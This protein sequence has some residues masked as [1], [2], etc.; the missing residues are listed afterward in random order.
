[1]G[2]TAS[3]RRQLI[4]LLCRVARADGQVVA[5]ERERLQAV[6]VR[7]GEHTVS[8]AE[9]DTWL[10]HGAPRV[11]GTLSPLARQAFMNEAMGV[12][13]ADRH[14][15]P[16]ELHAIREILKTY[17]SKLDDLMAG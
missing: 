11:A 4:A 6:L 15:D 13:A 5:E 17:F 2:L 8:G 14:I 7:L 1:M 9:L 3:E 12:V 16:A 10:E